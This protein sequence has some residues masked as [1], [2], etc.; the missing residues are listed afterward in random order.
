MPIVDLALDAGDD[1][2]SERL[3][4][5]LSDCEGEYSDSLR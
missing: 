1:L 3:V 2:I 4:A 5:V